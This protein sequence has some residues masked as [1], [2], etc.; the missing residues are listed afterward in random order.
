MP[1]S[2]RLLREKR[3]WVPDGLWR[4]FCIANLATWQPFTLILTRRIS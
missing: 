3:K 2:Y 1:D 4:A